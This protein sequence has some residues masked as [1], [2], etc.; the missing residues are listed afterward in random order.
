LLAQVDS[1]PALRLYRFSAVTDLKFVVELHGWDQGIRAAAFGG[2]VLVGGVRCATSACS[3]T[4]AELVVVSSSGT[5]RE[6]ATVDEHEGPPGDTDVVGIV[7]TSSAGVWVSDLEGRLIAFDNAGS[8]VAGPLSKVGEPCVIRSDLY[9]LQSDDAAETTAAPNGPAEDATGTGK[10]FA[11]QKW[12]GKQLVPVK[13]SRLEAEVSP[14]PNGFC[15]RGGFELPGPSSVARWTPGASW[16]E[17]AP[18]RQL[19]DAQTGIALSSSGRSYVVDSDGTLVELANGRA[20][21]TSVRFTTVRGNRPPLGLAVDDFYG[22]V[23]A[24]VQDYSEDA[25]SNSVECEVQ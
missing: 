13:N 22:V 4:V 19:H 1:K 16:H 2:G 17:V 25:A 23:V 9:M 7:G 18:Q 3:D 10:G 8:P 6:F 21:S 12:D 20:N 5:V 24:C 11:V 15:A 14:G